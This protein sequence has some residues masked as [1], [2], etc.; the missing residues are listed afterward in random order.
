MTIKFGIEQGGLAWKSDHPEGWFVSLDGAFVIDRLKP[1]VFVLA[2]RYREGAWQEVCRGGLGICKV[3]AEDVAAGR[4]VRLPSGN[5]GPA[6]QPKLQATLACCLCGQPLEGR[7]HNPTPVAQDGWCCD[8]CNNT[9]V[10][11]GRVGLAQ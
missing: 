4:L 3:F 10:L 8:A 6:R 1:G 2:H 7:G 11:P 5:Y 9:K